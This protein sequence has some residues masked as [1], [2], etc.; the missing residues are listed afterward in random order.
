MN[1][2][3]QFVHYSGG[4]FNTRE[5]AINYVKRIQPI[6]RPSLLAEP[7]I[8]LYKNEDDEKDPHVIL[9]IGS[10]GDGVTYT[11]DNR[12]FFIDTHKTEEEI[13]AIEDEIERVVKALTLYEKDSN[14]LN[15]SIERSPEGTTISGDVILSDYEIYE[16]Q[17]NHN[18]VQ[19]DNIL[20]QQKRVCL[21]LLTS[22]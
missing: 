5:D 21:P 6:E 13:A 22:I 17:E 15:L 16:N 8:M 18:K 1:S 20:Q 11:N 10:V 9:A 4:T 2:R 19:R 7:M 3:L 14:T 12:T